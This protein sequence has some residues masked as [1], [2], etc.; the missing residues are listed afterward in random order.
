MDLK[1]LNKNM[2]NKINNIN[3]LIMKYYLILKKS[4]SFN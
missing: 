1:I 2:E 3:K 4:N